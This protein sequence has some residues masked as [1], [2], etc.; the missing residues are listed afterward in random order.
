[1]GEC[2]IMITKNQLINSLT[3]FMIFQSI[4]PKVKMFLTNYKLTAIL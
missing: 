3:K 4:V 1:M 2:N